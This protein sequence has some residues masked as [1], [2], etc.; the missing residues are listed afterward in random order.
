ML[1]SSTVIGI[2]TYFGVELIANGD[3]LRRQALADQLRDASPKI[4]AAASQL[5]LTTN[6]ATATAQAMLNSFMD[7]CSHMIGTLH[8]AVN[9]TFCDSVR[10]VVYNAPNDPSMLGAVIIAVGAGLG[11]MGILFGITERGRK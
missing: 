8:V 5:N 10:D 11:L 9:S 4:L 1:S 2:S 6:N 7:N 3:E